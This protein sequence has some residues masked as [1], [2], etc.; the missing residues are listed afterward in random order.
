MRPAMLLLVVC[1]VV[2]GAT[3]YGRNKVQTENPD[4]WEISTNRYIV[5]YPVG[6]E[7]A[8][9]TLAGIAERELEALAEQFG[10]LPDSPVPIV[11]Y[12]SPWQFS[13]TDITSSELTEAVGGLTEYFKGRVVVPFTGDWSEF[14]HVVDHE[15]NHAFIYDMLYRRSLQAIILSNTPLWTIEGLAEYTSAGWDPASE[16]EFRDMVIGGQ[17]VSVQELSDRG[18]YLVYRE[19]QAIYHFMVERYGE[20]RFREFVRNLAGTDGLEGA[21][22]AAF[23]MPLGQF[24]EKF[25]EWARETYWAQLADRE[26]PGDVGTPIVRDDRP[27]CQIGSVVSRDGDRIAGV[28]G[29]HA[30]Y[31]VIIRSTVS[32]QVIRRCMNSGGIAD[33]GVSPLYRICAF[34][35]GGD[36]LAVAWHDVGCDRIAICTPEGREDLPL[37]FDLVRDPAWSPDGRYIAFVGLSEV[38]SDVYLYDLEAGALTRV[39]STP[40]GERDLSWG[41]AGLL[42][43]VEA[44]GGWSAVLLDP[45]GERTLHTSSGLRYPMMTD[46]GLVYLDNAGGAQD[47]FLLSGDGSLRRLTRLYRSIDSPSWADSAGV[48]TFQSNTWSECA[49]FEAYGLLTRP[50]VADS[51]PPPAS[52]ALPPDTAPPGAGGQGTASRFRIA[53]YSPGLST[54]YVTALAGYDSYVGLSGYTRFAFSDVLAHQRLYVDGD[55][56]GSVA[57]ADVAAYYWWLPERIDYGLMGYRQSNKY[58]FLFSDGHEEGVRDVDVGVAGGISYPFGPSSRVEAGV[59]YRHLT[60]TGYWDSDADYSADVL[61]TAA[62]LVMDNALWD[63]VGP[64][65][66]TR[67]S[68]RGELAPGWGTLSGYNTI[69]TDLRHYVWVSRSVT[70]ALRAAGASSWGENPQMFFVGG[71]VPNREILGEAEGIEDLVGFYGNYGDMLRGSEY[72]RFFGRNYGVATAELRIPFV[73]TLSLGAPIPMTLSNVRGAMFV[74]LGTAF[75]DP[76]SFRGADTDGGGFRLRDIGMGIGV[77]FRVNLGILLLREDTAW[78]TDLEGISERPRHYITLGASF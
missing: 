56:S 71:A 16:A 77:G 78:S 38:Q 43:S 73:N 34:S 33:T 65:V 52:N 9:D 75:D 18:D 36:S 17:A 3:S 7:A 57:D 1:A 35:P 40:A 69:S 45:A 39:T 63:W 48:M 27:V 32:G 12:V 58:L 66:G 26:N 53:P 30:S 10:Y 61:S 41:D 28:E 20:E 59:G 19:G 47:L 21:I 72:S 51:I 15:L 60:R 13:Q 37:E 8:A 55:F 29:W 6:A 70:L 14:R 76:A 49:V 25:T 68:L 23:D 31:A 50:G 74:D 62:G 42:A 54:D 4:W 22:R 2:C 46:S 64:R 24:D 5:Y 44:P 11:L 67:L